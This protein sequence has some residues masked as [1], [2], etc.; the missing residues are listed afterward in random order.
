MEQTVQSEGRYA[1]AEQRRNENGDD[2]V[3]TLFALS[4]DCSFYSR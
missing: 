3:S 4:A 2:Q 1:A